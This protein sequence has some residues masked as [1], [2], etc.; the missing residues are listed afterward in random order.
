MEPDLFL[1]A[2]VSIEASHMITA[3]GAFW[4]GGF[5]GP[6]VGGDMVSRPSLELRFALPYDDR[7]RAHS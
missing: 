2:E 4:K 5:R 7:R 1:P 3:S 6:T